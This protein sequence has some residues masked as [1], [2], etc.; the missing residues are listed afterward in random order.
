MRRG[1]VSFQVSLLAGRTD[2]RPPAPAILREQGMDAWILNAT[3]HGRGRI[4]RG[5]DR[6]EVEP[7]ELLL[8]PPRT[9]HDYGA[10]SHHRWCHLWVYFHPRPAWHELLRWPAAAGGVLRLDLRHARARPQVLRLFEDLLAAAADAAAP[11]REQL[12]LVLL[13]QLLLW[14][15][16]ANPLASAAPLDP[17]LA[18]A[19]ELLQAVRGPRL[20]L[21]QVARAV[22]MAPSHFAHRFR[23]EV[24][25]SPLQWL[26]AQRIERA[27]ELLLMSGRPI[28]EVG[29]DAGM[30]N[31]V[32]FA[33]LFRR[34][35]GLSPRQFRRQ[36]VPGVRASPPPA[37]DRSA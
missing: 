21:A 34:H 32:W 29:R 30:P 6:F 8:F 20:P 37:P 7:G 9:A 2:L 27:R 23:A 31:P 4:L 5:Q 16:A 26:E 3:T 35:T 28:A 22:G 10:A 1:V 15:D 17:R 18:Q 12:A 25:S 13:E 11:R 36:G 24:G 19:L 33:R 14:C